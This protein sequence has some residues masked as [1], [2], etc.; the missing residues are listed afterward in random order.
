MPDNYA[1]LL[2]PDRARIFRI[3]HRA[4]LA[5]VLQYGLHCGNSATRSP[6]WVSIGNQELIGKRAVWPV[7]TAPGGVLNDYVPFY[8]TP[9]SPMM[10]NIVTGYNGVARH[11]KRDIVI[12]VTSLR[13]VEEMGLTFLF[14]FSHANNF[15]V[16]YS[17]DL[18][19]LTKLDWKILQSRDFEYDADDPTKRDRY[20]AET[21]VHKHLPVQG[22]SGIVCHDEHVKMEVEQVVAECGLQLPVAARAN[23][24]F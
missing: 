12:L 4:N 23:W 7:G 3:I 2:N 8:F 18:S 21:L 17:S 5:W 9:F 13:R 10:L 22:L 14:T 1:A 15:R 6:G 20:Q 24:Y 19:D 16:D 11:P